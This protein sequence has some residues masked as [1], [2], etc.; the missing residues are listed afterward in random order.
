MYY[1]RATDKLVQEQGE[2]GGVIT[3]VL[4]AA[5]EQKLVDG[6]LVIKR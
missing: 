3:A 5:V 1:G 4:I 2:C 6:A